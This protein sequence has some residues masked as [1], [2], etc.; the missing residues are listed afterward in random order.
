M[1]DYVTQKQ[2]EE[3]LEKAFVKNNRLIVDGISETMSA[4]MDRIDE[5]FNKVE[6]D[7]IDIKASIDRLTNTLDGF[8]KRLEDYEVESRA[9]DAQ[10]ERLVVWAKEVS[11]KTGI[12]MP[13][14]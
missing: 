1:N 5:R 12:P 3:T 13:Q 2:L 7:I 4:M 11:K 8:V 9:R 10:F 6:E 14:L